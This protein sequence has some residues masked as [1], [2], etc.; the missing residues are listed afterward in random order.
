MNIKFTADFEG[1]LD[2]IAEGKAKW[3][4]ILNQ[5]YQLFNPICEK[6]L[7]NV[8]S[9]PTIVNT[10]ILIGKDPNT[11]LE[12]FKGSGKYGPYVK[13]LESV[14]STKWKFAPSK[15]NANITLEDAI[16]LLKYPLLLG[17]ISKTNIYLNKGQFGFYVKYEDR[18][19]HIKDVKE[20]DI[21][22]EKVRGLIE[23]PVV[24]Q[25]VN[26]NMS[27]SKTFTVKNKTFNVRTGE[28]G[29]Y[30][31]IV[32]GSTKTNMSIS[33]DIDIDSITIEKVLELIANKKGTTKKPYKKF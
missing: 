18:N 12:I 5:F 31:Q 6:L 1:Y 28:F 21:T 19:I 9:N 30:I 15:N 20:E 23:N 17:K 27:G 14:D 7:T 8:K 16:S 3:F 24:K 4:N 32:S 22:I 2:K 26:N 13:R 33:K 25:N 10:D 29:P 11:N